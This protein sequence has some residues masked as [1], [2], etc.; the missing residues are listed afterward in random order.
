MYLT[1]LSLAA[2]NGVF[3]DIWYLFSGKFRR[4]H[5]AVLKGRLIHKTE[6]NSKCASG[7]SY[8]LRRNVHRMEKGL[9]MRPRRKVFGLAFVEETS[10]LFHELAANETERVEKAGMLVWARDVLQEYFDAVDLGNLTI[11]RAY[12]IF[13]D[14]APLNSP[15]SDAKPYVRALNEPPSFSI[16]QFH[17]LA[18]RR[19]SCRW[20]LEKAVPRAVIDQ[21]IEIG[22]LAPSACNRQP[23]SFHIFDDPASAKKIGALP[24]GT[25]GFCHNFPCIAVLVGDLSAFPFERDRHLPYIDASLA[26]MG[27]QFALELEGVSSCCI[28]WPDIESK[29]RSISTALKLSGNQRVI[30]LI[31]FGYPDPTAM[32]PYSKKK[33]LDEIRSYRTYAD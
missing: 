7:A 19:R 21:A 2:S 6:L 12:K 15:L 30:M 22:T 17:D 31:A 3:A 20:F 25:K 24:G 14:S 1:G 26:A 13:Q 23:F 27:F 18:V 8:T 11:S 29:E 28:N 10:I 16:S 32:V 5:L 33:S 4:E 9:I